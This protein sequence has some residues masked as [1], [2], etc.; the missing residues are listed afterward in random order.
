MVFDLESDGDYVMRAEGVNGEG[1]KGFEKL[2]TS[3]PMAR[4]VRCPSSHS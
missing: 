1:K 2:N 4:S 3:S